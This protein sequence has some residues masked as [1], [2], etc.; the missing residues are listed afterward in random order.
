[1]ALWGNKDSKTA[2]GTIAITT[3][4]AVTGSSTAFTTQAKVGNTI[5]AGG[6]DYEI[7]VITDNTH[8]T[9]RPGINGG[10]MA[11]VNAGASYT[12]SEKPAYVAASESGGNSNLVYGVD[13]TEVSVAGEVV[14]LQIASGGSG[15][16]EAP[17]L[18]FAAAPSGGTTATGTATIS[19]G[20]VTVVAITGAGAGY[21]AVPAVTIAP[22]VM[23]VPASAVNTSANSI[24][25]N[26]HGQ[27]TGDAVVY[28]NGGGTTLAGLTNGTTYYVIKLTAN[29]FSL[30][31]S[32]ADAAVPTAID[33]TGAGNNA[34]N[35]LIVAGTTA[36]AASDLSVGTGAGRA[37]AHAGWVRKTVGTGNRAGRVQYE[38]L[39]AMSSGSIV[40]DAAD[41]GSFPD[42]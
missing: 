11:A 42:A 3:A 29:T 23:T 18:S 16:V 8:A 4:G 7:T 12:L 24:T 22:P 27:N 5:R 14:N 1:M 20:K 37:V 31:A 30:A 13:S 9:V 26:A 28:R 39:V 38:T 34:Q 19:G 10:T 21:T 2:S 36:T 35:F 6:A 17:G 33:L 40:A 15:Y 41:D 25:Y 32:A